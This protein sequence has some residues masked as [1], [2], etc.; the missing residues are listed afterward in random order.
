[1]RLEG[2][3]HDGS[4]NRIRQTSLQRLLPEGQMTGAGEVIQAI[5]EY[6][7]PG[8]AK[9]TGTVQRSGRS[10]KRHRSIRVLEND[11]WW[12]SAARAKSASRKYRLEHGFGMD[13]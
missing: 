10:F 13:R 8:E 6:V 4:S 5:F 7:R 12:I 11:F 1:M 9:I 2:F 3:V